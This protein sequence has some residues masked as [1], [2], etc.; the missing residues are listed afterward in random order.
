M[1]SEGSPNE[2]SSGAAVWVRTPLALFLAASLAIGTVVAAAMTMRAAVRQ[3]DEAVTAEALALGEVERLR[4]LR[5][6][7]SRKVRSYLLL[8]DDRFLREVRESEREF[9]V[10]LAEL[11]DRTTSADE[12]RIIVELEAREG[13]RRR[14]TDRLIHMHQGGAGTR[15]ITHV[16]ESE[17]Q[18]IVDAM[19]VS[20]R[21]LVEWH[22]REVER[23]RMEASST[24]RHATIVLGVAASIALVVAALTSITLGK[25]LRR[26]EGRAARLERERNRF[27]ELSIDMVCVASTD[28]YFKQLNPAFEAVLG[29]TRAELLDKPFLDFVHADDRQRTIDVVS[30]LS[31]GETTVDFEN[32]Y[33][34]KNGDYKWLSWHATPEPGGAIYA[35]ARDVSERKAHEERLA[36]LNEELR[37]M[38]VIDDLTGL[39]NR[40]GFNLLAEQHLKN[41]QRTQQKAVFFFADLDGLKQIND[42]LGHD[43]G[44]RAIREAAKVIATAFRS[45]DISARLGGDEFVVLA[46]NAA[47]E[48]AEAIVRRVQELVSQFNSAKPEPPFV[49]A[50]S[51]G[52]TTYDPAHPETIDEVLKRAD[53]MMYEQKVRRKA[54]AAKAAAAAAKRAISDR[55]N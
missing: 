9:N 1:S 21:D 30:G 8:A 22:Q 33:L 36:A 4:A 32:R 29:Y 20:A 34:C 41:V 24:F 7:V 19:D 11:R 47:S 12:L 13:T 17:L 18:P 14:V 42:T 55:P 46:T 49:L 23:A 26:L 2:G 51:I 25:T 50:I 31:R 54:L 40:R 37:I 28:G 5:E 52:S 48:G 45:S 15:A 38:A 35:V 39:H 3:S 43:V 44:D 10:L 6:R 16:L 27:F 53:L